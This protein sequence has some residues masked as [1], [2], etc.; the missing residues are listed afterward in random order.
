MAIRDCVC[1][2]ERRPATIQ[3]SGGVKTAVRTPRTAR[4][5]ASDTDGARSLGRPASHVKEQSGFRMSRLTSQRGATGR[6]ETPAPPVDRPCLGVHTARGIESHSA[7][8]LRCRAETLLACRPIRYAKPLRVLINGGSMILI[9][10]ATGFLGG[11]VCR[12]LVRAEKLCADW[13]ARHPTRGRGR[14]LR[15][16][17]VE[18]VLGDVRDRDSLEPPAA[19]SGLLSRPSRRLARA[20]PATASRRRTNPGSSPSSMPRATPGSSVLSTSRTRPTSMTTAR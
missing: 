1:S 4:Q 17:G 15:A 3:A 13:C 5:L 8:P 10:G 11:E 19:A 6:S 18:T 2:S 14:R 16:L 9:A 12:R 7:A 20:N